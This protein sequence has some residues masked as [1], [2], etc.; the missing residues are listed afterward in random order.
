MGLHFPSFDCNVFVSSQVAHMTKS[1]MDLL[2]TVFIGPG[3]L[4]LNQ[5][6]DTPLPESLLLWIAMVSEVISQSTGILVVSR[7]FD[8]YL[9]SVWICS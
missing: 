2:D 8:S 3:L 6:F 7:G 9:S 5:Y 1:P 4:F